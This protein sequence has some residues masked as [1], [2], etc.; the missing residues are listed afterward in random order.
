MN[1]GDMH[2]PNMEIAKTAPDALKLLWNKEFFL[3][4][5]TFKDIENE[6]TKTG[7]NFS[8]Y[9]LSMALKSAK[10]LTRYGQKGSY[11][12]R[13]KYPF[14]EEEKQKLEKIK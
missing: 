7:Y 13:Q 9:N 11:Y 14:I 1:N 2:N 3:Q 8:K 5:K 6:L 4:N 10:F 12:Y